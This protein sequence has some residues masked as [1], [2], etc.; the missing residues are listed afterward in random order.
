MLVAAGQ[1]AL[2]SMI[3]AHSDLVG[4]TDPAQVRFLS[5]M[6]HRRRRFVSVHEF[7]LT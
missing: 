6:Q 7:Q 2:N 3:D 1:Q 5:S 4:A